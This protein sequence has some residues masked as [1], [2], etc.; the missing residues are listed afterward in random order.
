MDRFY[1]TGSRA[2]GWTLILCILLSLSLCSA[3][4]PPHPIAQRTRG[5][6]RSPPPPPRPL[7]AGQPSNLPSVASLRFSPL[8]RTLL[9]AIRPDSVPCFP[10]PPKN[11]QDTVVSFPRKIR[12][13]FLSLRSMLDSWGERRE[14]LDGCELHTRGAEY[15]TRAEP[16]RCRSKL[17]AVLPCR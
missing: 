12:S 2:H 5:R 1:S 16:N 13:L 6:D 7:H 14:E 15:A 3:P 10:S 8:A 11:L 9:D 4:T 17:I